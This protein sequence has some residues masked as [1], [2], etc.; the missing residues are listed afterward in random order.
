MSKNK[1]PIKRARNAHRQKISNLSKKTAMRT[2][3]KN[4]EAAV[5]DENR[6]EAEATLMAAISLIDHNECR[7]IIHKNKAARIKS[8]LTKKFK[9]LAL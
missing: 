1:T 7:K 9:T 5:A 3:I 4:F 2:A 8:R 6:S